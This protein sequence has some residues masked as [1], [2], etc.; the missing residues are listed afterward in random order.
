MKDASLDLFE[1]GH[2]PVGSCKWVI[3]SSSPHD[4]YYKIGIT[5]HDRIFFSYKQEHYR[6]VA[7]FYER[8]LDG[9]DRKSNYYLLIQRNLEHARYILNVVDKGLEMNKL[10]EVP[11][12]LMSLYDN[13]G[14]VKTGFGVDEGGLISRY[15]GITTDGIL[16]HILDKAI[17][18]NISKVYYTIL[19][20]Y[21]NEPYTGNL[22]NAIFD[23]EAALEVICGQEDNSGGINL[24]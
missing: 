13:W 5:K 24:I 23:T 3:G 16:L 2:E 20:P 17:F 7:R 19:A 9:W 15:Y 21:S 10:T 18:M 6:N 22:L 8:L 11:D 4:L 14:W 12:E 1:V